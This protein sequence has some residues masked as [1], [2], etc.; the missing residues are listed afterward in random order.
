MPEIRPSQV[1]A[2]NFVEK[3]VNN[4]FRDIIL[5][6]PTGSGKGPILI[7]VC[8]WAKTLDLEGTKG[9]YY[10]TVQKLL[11]KQLE[12]D[13]H[14]LTPGLDWVRSIK[15]AVDY[16]CATHKNCGFGGLSKKKKCFCTTCPYKVAKKEFLA[17]TVGVTNYAYFFAERRYAGTLEKRQVLALDEVHRLE[18]ELTRF[19]D[20]KISESML[21]KY[22]PSILSVPDLRSL[23]ELIEWTENTYVKEAVTRLGVLKDLAEE[24]P[25]DEFAKDAYA[26]DQH[27]GKILNALKD[28]K[29]NPKQW[30]FWSDV[31]SDKKTELIARPLHAAPFMEEMVFSGASLRI[32]ASAYPG[33]KQVFCRSLGLNPETTP[34]IKLASDFP[35]KNRRVLVFGVG[36]MGRKN[37]ETTFPLL[38]KAVLKIVNKH[39]AER[40]IV[41]GNSYDVCDKIYACLA[42]TEHLPRLIYPKK[43][44]QREDAFNRHAATPASI[45]ITP[46]MGE[47]FDFKDDLARWQIVPKIPWP[48]LGD[49]Q[50]K[51]KSDLDP[52]WYSCEAVK[53]IIQICG[54]ATRSMTDYSITY[55]LDEDFWYLYR[56]A[57]HMFPRWFLDAV[58]D[59]KTKRN[60]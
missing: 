15:S 10:L 7:A 48:S 37:Q 42:E 27:V 17:S 57:E 5:S 52:D 50:V 29:T 54:R 1:K 12:D 41:H 25:T 4:G 14:K 22:A 16:P 21:E 8:N 26:L 9:G 44:D 59:A 58:E 39:S 45:L 60:A 35:T 28:A 56:K 46:S 40:G 30:I 3:S 31:D 33:D 36:S 47:G 20:L 38:L 13:R 11:Q 19:V 51:A 24:N 43:A 18:K 23:E 32:Y 34:M 6:A 49:R 55:V 2:L 53:S